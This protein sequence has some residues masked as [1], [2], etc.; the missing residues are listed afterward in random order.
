MQ[1]FRIF[2]P[3]PKKMKKLMLLA[4]VCCFVFASCKQENK[5][6]ETTDTTVVEQPAPAPVVNQDSLDQ[7]QAMTDWSNW[8]TITPER[9][10]E[11]VAK[12]K[13]CVEKGL[14]ECQ[15][16][17][18][19]KIAEKKAFEKKWAKFDKLTVDEQKALIDEF[20]CKHNCGDQACCNGEN[21]DCKKECT[22]ECTK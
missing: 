2:K 22:K 15:P 8:E 6:V 13:T 18:K 12:F 21:K 11:L 9:K 1:T 14:A 20:P 4:A 3:K 19:A 10:A 5:P 16:T 17:E 7:V